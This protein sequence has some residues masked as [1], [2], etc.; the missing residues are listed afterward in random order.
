MYLYVV[1]QWTRP[2][3][4]VTGLRHFF[5]G[6]HVPFAGRHRRASLQRVPDAVAAVQQHHVAEHHA[7]PSTIVRARRT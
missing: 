1:W 4:P 2:N 5:A 6:A 7:A 3:N